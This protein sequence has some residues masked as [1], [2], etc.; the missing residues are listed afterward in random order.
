MEAYLGEMEDMEHNSETKN[1]QNCKKDFIIEPDDFSFYVK[2]KVPAPTWCPE[3]RSQRRMSWRNVRNLYR[4][5]CDGLGH[6]ENIITTFSVDKK[7]ISYDQK[8]WWSDA[9]DP[10]IYGKDYD[11]SKPFFIQF[12]E[13][14]E[15]VPLPNISNLNGIDT[16][17][18][19]MTIDS[20]NCFLVFSANKNENCSYSEGINDCQNVL[21]TLT[22]HNNNY[23][24]ECIECS[25]S[26]NLTFS[27]KAVNCSDSYFLYDCKNCSNCFGCWNLRNKNYCIFNEQLTKEKFIE[28]IDNFNLQSYINLIKFKDIFS[29]KSKKCIRKFANIVGSNNVSGNGI[30]FSNNCHN[31]YD[32][33]KANNS[34]Y[35]WRFLNIGGSD[36]YDITV[37]SKPELCYEGQGVGN[38]YNLKFG[39]ASGNASNSEYSHSCVSNSSNLFG[40]VSLNSKQYCI[41]NKQ[42]T[43]EEYEALVS[44][45]IQ[46][47]NDMPYIDS[48]GRIYKYGE[49]FPSELS[50]FAYN[51]TIAQEYF[52][53]TKEQAIEQGYKW[54]E[55]V[56]R[57]YS[58]DI[59]TEDIPDSIKDIPDID[60]LNKVIECSHKGTCNQQCTEAFK[61]IPEELSFYRRMNLPIPRLCPNC[62]HYERLSQ[63]NPMKLWHR[64]CMKEG[65]TNTFETSYAPERPEII[66]C[67]KCYQKEVY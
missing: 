46:H 33:N 39:V 38:A 23:V 7:F 61:I 53:L 63:R 59:H 24:Y 62:R 12:K 56:D 9:W 36:N 40:C 58:I 60:I 35:V 50:P 57:D 19:N 26:F 3:C 32:I 41:L 55:K 48:K 8:L 28:T 15:K 47:M 42:Y 11:F 37:G 20:K 29:K 54:K 10:L 14:L 2:I 6:N 30:E 65:C 31:S 51:E 43:K 67:E 49:F 22:S 64:Q 18:A 27:E 16:E 45:I 1:C 25:N 13:L 52:P 44:K 34:S 4:R 5:K 17:Y 21:D 66:Y